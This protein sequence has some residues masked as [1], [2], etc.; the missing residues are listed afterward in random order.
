MHLFFL[1]DLF[2]M[3]LILRQLLIRRAL[4]LPTY[5]IL[6]LIDMCIVIHGHFK[7]SLINT[8]NAIN[9][10]MDTLDDPKEIKLINDLIVQ[11]RERFTILLRRYQ[12][13]SLSLTKI[14]SGLIE[15]N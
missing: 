5:L 9:I 7:I 8:L 13:H 2:L 1:I 14:C 6:I 15:H 3:Y 12:E 4:L 10:N 11:E